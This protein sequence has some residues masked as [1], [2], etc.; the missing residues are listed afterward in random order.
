MELQQLEYFQTVAEMLHITRAAEALSISQPAL[1]R[2]ISRL[3]K[4]LGVPLF[5]RYGRS[6]VLNRYGQMFLKR[7]NSIIQELSAGKQEICDLLDPEYGEISL[8]FL[9]TLGVH[10]IPDLIGAFRS[11]YP[12]VK[13]LL[14]ENNV[15]ML[16]AQM[17][18]GDIDLCFATY[19]ET[20]IPVKWT[21]LWS[22][23]LFVIVPVN[24][25]LAGCKSINLSEI[26]D[27]SFISFKEGYGLRIITD[28]LC[29]EA[30][31]AP[32]IKFEGEEVSTIAGLVAA[33]LGVS[34]IP[35]SKEIDKSKIS[36]ISVQWPK[37]QRT[38]QMANVKE[39][40]LSPVI[41][42]FKQFTLEYFKLV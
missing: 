36:Q 30:G 23:E 6:I 35:D 21:E 4:E 27:E 26:A 1:S 20:K 29:K 7:V 32:K 42:L 11:K 28:Q 37:C 34:L 24:H 18:A 3:E 40:Y 41:K 19:K 2:S 8:G 13:F 25:R 10:V 16:L 31:I 39:R 5:D 17:E 38:I 9:H 33:G 14:H 22:E 12:N 15:Q